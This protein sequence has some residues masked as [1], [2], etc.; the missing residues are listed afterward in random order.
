MC[1]RFLRIADNGT[2]VPR[3]TQAPLT[4]PGMLSRTGHFDQSGIMGLP[5]NSMLTCGRLST[6]FSRLSPRTKYWSLPHRIN[7]SRYC[8][9][10]NVG[11]PGARYTSF[12]LHP[13]RY[14]DP[15][16]K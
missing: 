2:R 12:S 11:V 15:S 9:L 10:L 14:T 3:N 1:F 8:E 4:F 6:E 7:L 13:L 5:S 16:F